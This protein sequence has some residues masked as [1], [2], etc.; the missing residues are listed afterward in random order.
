MV[1]YIN[2]EELPD[3]TV[4]VRVVYPDG[5]DVKNGAHQLA[6]MMLKYADSIC[7]KSDV[8][9]DSSPGSVVGKSPLIIS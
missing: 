8:V 6:N 2:L 5:F 3:R 1:C 7:I 9:V 4:S